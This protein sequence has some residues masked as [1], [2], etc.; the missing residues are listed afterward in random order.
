MVV[1]TV[2]VSEFH[3]HAARNRLISEVSAVNVNF[4]DRYRSSPMQ[5]SIKLS[6]FDLLSLILN[7]WRRL[8]AVQ[9]KAV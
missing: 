3:D 7:L 2:C 4:D 1:R 5:S 6:L 8:L 9:A